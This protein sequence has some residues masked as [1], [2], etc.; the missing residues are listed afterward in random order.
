MNADVT[1]GNRRVSAAPP[2]EQQKFARA[3]LLIVFHEL[4]NSTEVAGTASLSLSRL[5][6]K[7]FGRSGRESF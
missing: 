4:T 5:L 6:N 1:A 2:N 3:C 7:T